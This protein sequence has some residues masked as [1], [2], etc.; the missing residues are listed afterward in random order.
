MHLLHLLS[1]CIS[2]HASRVVI[3]GREITSSLG[4]V[5]DLDTCFLTPSLASTTASHTDPR[6]L[7]L[8][9]GTARQSRMW[10]LWR[11]GSALATALHEHTMTRNL[12]GICQKTW[13]YEATPQ[14]TP[15][16]EDEINSKDTI[17]LSSTTA[18]AR[19]EA[20]TGTLPLHSFSSIRVPCNIHVFCLFLTTRSDWQGRLHFSICC[21][22]ARTFSTRESFLI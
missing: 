2:A 14:S 10:A 13:L 18:S 15:S 11:T 3:S 20:W 22:W 12:M 7:S 9:L 21:P 6:K 16:L 19:L 1:V 8:R 4:I 5:M 17:F